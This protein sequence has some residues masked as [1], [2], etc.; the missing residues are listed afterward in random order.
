MQVEKWENY[1]I[2]LGKECSDKRY[3][4]ICLSIY[5][6]CPLT[7]K[8]FLLTPNVSIIRSLFVSEVEVSRA[9]SY[10]EP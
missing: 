8:N 2:E 4:L 3:W 6:H 9:V 7:V 10:T 1:L 5:C